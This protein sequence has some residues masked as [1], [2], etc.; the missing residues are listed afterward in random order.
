V[1]LVHV[2]GGIADTGGVIGFGTSF[3][4]VNVTGA[5][6]DLSGPG[7]TATNMAFS[8]PRNGTLTELSVFFSLVAATV[9]VIPAGSTLNVITQLYRSTVPDNTFTPVPGAV[10][11]LS[12]P[13]PFLLVQ[14]PP[15]TANGTVAIVVPV[16]N[17]DRL[18]LVT[19]L[20]ATGVDLA[21]V[22]SGYISAGLAIV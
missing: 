17:Q 1:G 2:L 6:I 18:L 15:T 4:T 7:G 12:F 19:K 22:V 3:S 21:D 13:G 5:T 16:L 10:V 14:V 9:L 20:T 11:T 8:M